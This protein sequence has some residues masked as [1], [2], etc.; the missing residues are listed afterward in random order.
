MVVRFIMLNGVDE[1]QLQRTLRFR[2][3]LDKPLA[4]AYGILVDESTDEVENVH[5]Q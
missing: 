5:V 3:Q 4:Q 2:R 1:Q